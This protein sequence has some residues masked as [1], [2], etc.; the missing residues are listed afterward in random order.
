MTTR[1]ERIQRKF[2]WGPFEG[3]F[4]Y[5]LVVWDKVCSPIEM[6]GLGIRN[7]VSFNQALVGKWLW[8]Y[9]YEVTHL[10]RRVIST[11]YGEGQG[12]WSTKVCRTHGVVCDVLL[13]KGGRAF[14]SIFFCYG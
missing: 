10:W 14:L 1:L 4:K 6:G 5:L 2:L 9:G 7:A 3:S 12:G 8:R 11:K 13:V